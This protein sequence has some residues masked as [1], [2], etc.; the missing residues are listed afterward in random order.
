MSSMS[1]SIVFHTGYGDSLFSSSWTPNDAGSYAATCIFLVFFAAVYRGLFALK[2]ILEQRWLD[3]ARRRRYITVAGQ[4]RE[5]ER[6]DN[7]ADA[8]KMVLLTSQGVEEEVRVI[9]RSNRG[10]MP[11]RWSTDLPRAFMVLLVTLVGFLLMLAVMT[12]NTGYFLSILA[13]VFL[14]ELVVGR[15]IQM[16]EH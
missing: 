15:Y 14:G 4:Q 6:I 2:S 13:G 5:S 8:K 11:W 3:A 1:M 16:D 10:A 9:A 12:L 7:D